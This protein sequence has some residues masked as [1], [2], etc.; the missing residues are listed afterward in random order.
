M[1]AV[2]DAQSFD[3]ASKVFDKCEIVRTEDIVT[4]YEFLSVSFLSMMMCCL[5]KGMIKRS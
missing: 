5:L 4:S 3:F 2:R 1:I